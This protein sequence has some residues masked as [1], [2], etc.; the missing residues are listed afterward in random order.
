MELKVRADDHE[1][2]HMLIEKSMYLEQRT[3][4][5]LKE[6]NQMQ[7]DLKINEESRM[8]QAYLIEKFEQDLKKLKDQYEAM[9]KENYNQV[10]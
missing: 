1:K 8:Q 5:L 3:E 7:K 6:R 2:H 9:K 10:N 4:D